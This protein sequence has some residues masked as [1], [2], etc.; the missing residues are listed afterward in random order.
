MLNRDEEETDSAPRADD[1]TEVAYRQVRGLILEGVFAPGSQLPIAR[2]AEEF[3]LSRTPVR[4]AS[5]RLEQEGFLVRG[6]G[7]R[8]V[9]ADIAESD[10]DSWYSVR[11]MVETLGVHATVPG[12]QRAEL[13]RLGALLKE[14]KAASKD[15][16]LDRW[17][18]P[19]REFHRIL[20]GGA[21]EAI[22]QVAESM[23]ERTEWARRLR[24]MRGA[25]WRGAVEEHEVLLRA[26]RTRQ[27]DEVAAALAAHYSKTVRVVMDR[28]DLD[29]TSVALTLGMIRGDRS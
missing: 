28:E 23:S 25:R 24:L 6:R 22:R 2:L 26:T 7:L 21:G 27:V 11:I 3:G 8:P 4:E 16:D 20:I 15:G 1:L 29:G 9:V 14:M 13:T 17:E 12:M 5:R 18:H 19:H 10:L